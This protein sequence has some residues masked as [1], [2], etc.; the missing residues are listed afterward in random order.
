ML[1]FRMKMLSKENL[2]ARTS[3]IGS[4]LRLLAGK[5]LMVGFVVTISCYGMEQRK[6]QA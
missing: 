1:R 6:Q 3:D 4:C 5:I 2:M